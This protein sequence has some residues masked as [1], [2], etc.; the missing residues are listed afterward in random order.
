MQAFYSGNSVYTNGDENGLFHTRYWEMSSSNRGCTELDLIDVQID[1]DFFALIV[2]YPSK[3]E[4]T[5]TLYAKRVTSGN[6]TCGWRKR[7][8]GIGFEEV[9]TGVFK[10]TAEYL[11]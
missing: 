6:A 5:R 9:A 10:D 2:C 3:P 7:K 11:H 8:G 1:G 4:T